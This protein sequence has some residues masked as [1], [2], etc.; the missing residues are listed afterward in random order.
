MRRYLPAVA[1]VAGVLAVAAVTTTVVVGGGEPREAVFEPSVT[2]G[3]PSDPPADAS[4]VPMDTTPPCPPCGAVNPLPEDYPTNPQPPIR[5]NSNE[6]PVPVGAASGAGVRDP[7]GSFL[8]FRKGGSVISFTSQGWIIELSVNAED[9]SAFAPTIEALAAAADPVVLN[10]KSFRVPRGAIYRPPIFEV[11]PDGFVGP[12]DEW[13]IYHVIKRGET[14]VSF[15]RDGTV[16]A[17]K[18]AP[19]DAEDFQAV[20]DALS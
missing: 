2:V 7:G 10:K 14:L 13:P 6:I 5:V 9:V 3:A 12:A 8:F 19:G 16:I 17:M 15:D 18:V 20:V 4:I 11:L 1:G